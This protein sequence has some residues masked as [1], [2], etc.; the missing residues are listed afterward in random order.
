MKYITYKWTQTRLSSSLLDVPA[1]SDFSEESVEL[2]ELELVE[3][4]DDILIK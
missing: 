4:F 3:L 1:S 2:L